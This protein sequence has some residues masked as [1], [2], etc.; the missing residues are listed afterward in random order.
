M[1]YDDHG[2]VAQMELEQRIA[3]PQ[4]TSSKLV[5]ATLI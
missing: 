2:A 4:V 5:G 1:I 3:N